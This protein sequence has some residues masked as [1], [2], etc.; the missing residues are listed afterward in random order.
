MSRNSEG[1]TLIEL[2][3]V[4]GIFGL[5]MLASYTILETTIEADRRVHEAT[6]TGKVG[7]A[8]LSQMRR[9]LQ[10]TIWR[11][12]GENIFRGESR[13]E[14]ES[15]EDT[16]DFLTTSPIPEPTETITSYT[17]EVSSVGYALKSGEDGD[18]ILFRR[19]AWD[20]DMDPLD[21]GDRT[22]IYDRVKAMDFRFLDAEN[23]WVGDWDSSSLLPEVNE[24]DFPFLDEEERIEAEE[25]ALAE[26]DPNSGGTTTTPNAGTGAD[27]DP[28]TGEPIPEEPLPIP[29]PRAVEVILY[30]H[31]GDERGRIL[32]SSGNPLM[33]VFS[34]VIPLIV[35]DQ[36]LLPDPE[37]V[38]GEDLLGN[39]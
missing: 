36:L 6:M 5:V 29:I 20:M 12:L 31:Y 28:A 24:S 26:N 19:V 17:G 8:I 34:T 13:G 1:F 30:L 35:T 15:A 18:F 27:I 11:G 14:D 4:L 23:N 10:G 3:V 39:F 37:E 25:A 22:A 2:V 38:L 7:E 16:I 33:E 32:D 9:D 21:T